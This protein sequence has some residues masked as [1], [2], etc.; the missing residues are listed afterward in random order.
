MTGKLLRLQALRAVAASLV[1]IDHAASICVSSGFLPVA[2]HKAIWVLGHLGVDIFFV[3]SGLIM[4]R[5]TNA[6]AAGVSTSTKFAIG[7]L[8]RVAPLYWLA[9]ALFSAWLIA[10]GKTVDPNALIASLFFIPHYAPA[11]AT[12]KPVLLAGWTLNYE[13]MFY[14]LFAAGLFLRKDRRVLFLLATLS[15]IVIMGAFHHRLIPRTEPVDILQFWSDPIILLFGL[16]ATIAAFEDP[17]K[18]L[19]RFPARVILTILAII[20]LTF[21]TGTLLHAEIPIQLP[22]LAVFAIVSGACVLLCT[23]VSDM[24]VTPFSNLMT[25]LGDSSYAT[26]LFGF[27]VLI[28][29]SPLFHVLPKSY[30]SAIVIIIVLTVAANALGVAVHLMVEKPLAR[31]LKPEQT[32][33]SALAPI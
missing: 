1:A 8:T 14:T 19:P 33:S 25:L 12:V 10:K 9:T 4:V 6:Q 11:L 2:L 7:R 13:M 27:I 26:Y 31:W 3:I 29:S 32:K 21:L 15:A 20:V 17:V 5:T 28:A 16:G 22:W 18:T 24:C 30:G 23:A